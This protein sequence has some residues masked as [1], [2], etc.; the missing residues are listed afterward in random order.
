MNA[1][2]LDR[3]P[4]RR[5]AR[6]CGHERHEEILAS[7]RALFL[8]Y[9]AENVSTRQIAARVGISQTCLY[10]Y[11]K[12]KDEMLDA[13]VEATLRKLAA[14]LDAANARFAEPIE[15]LSAMLRAYIRFGLDHPDEYRLAFMA[16]D[17]RRRGRRTNPV[18]DALFDALQS[19]IAQGVAA[20]RLRAAATPRATAEAAWA[21]VHGLVALR[22]AHPDRVWTPLG[23]AI[24]A[25]LDMLLKG[26]VAPAANTV[27][28]SRS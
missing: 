15:S 12:S 11:F 10:V 8:E 1:L 18:G 23:E 5:K 4:E 26:L 9:G 13:L 25:H 28:S 2:T 20:G 27:S 19:R 21:S 24:D 3:A 22:L 14:A 16:R 6:G 17:G 7:A